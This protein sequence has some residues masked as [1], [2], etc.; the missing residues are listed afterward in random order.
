M[1]QFFSVTRTQD[2][3]QMGVLVKT[4]V[5]AVARSGVQQHHTPTKTI[6]THPH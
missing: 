4:V 1:S 5:V 6:N 3:S 2:S